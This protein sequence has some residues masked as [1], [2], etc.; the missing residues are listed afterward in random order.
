MSR[1]PVLN[2]SSWIAE[3]D[4]FGY[5]Y[6]LGRHATS[7]KFERPVSEVW[8]AELEERVR[9]RAANMLCAFAHPS[10]RAVIFWTRHA[11]DGA[12]KWVRRLN[13][14]NEAKPLFEKARVIYPAHRAM[15]PT[16][17]EHKWTEK[18]KLKV[19]F[20]GTDYWVKNGRVTLGLFR[21]LA[22]DFPDVRFTYVG[23]VPPE[24][25]EL[26]EGI[27]FRGALPRTEVL[28][29]FK[30]SHILFH[31]AREESFGMVFVEAAAHGLAVVAAKS[32]GLGHLDE[33]LDEREAMLVPYDSTR[34][35]PGEEDFEAYL[36]PLLDDP[37]LAKQKALAFYEMALAGRFS[38]EER[39][40]TLR[41]VYQQALQ[42]RA[43]SGFSLAALPYWK[44][45]ERL[46]LD[47]ERISAACKRFC[48]E[49]GI[50]KVNFYIHL[51]DQGERAE[52]GAGPAKAA[53]AT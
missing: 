2:R 30:E 31:P 52:E 16:L 42:N 24:A 48:E 9:M 27:D 43:Q 37:D 13:L 15:L 26:A 14:E 47:G 19:L 51:D 22:D 8:T 36:R 21:R 17:V 53:H 23:V 40:K 5:P 39:N 50:R 32:P 12:Q 4:D 49:E 11:L 25:A 38:V 33:I 35:A 10:C 41:A 29:L 28:K 18:S 1:W 45:F 46:T 7:R 20:V 44:Q 3:T 34:E 6:M